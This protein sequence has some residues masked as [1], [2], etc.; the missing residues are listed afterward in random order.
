MYEI[1]DWLDGRKAKMLAIAGVFLGMASR[2]GYLDSQ[3]ATDI[4]SILTIMAGGAS[5]ATDKVIGSFKY[6]S[7]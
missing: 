2:L 5:V 7:K 3:I 1:L 6:R 4:L